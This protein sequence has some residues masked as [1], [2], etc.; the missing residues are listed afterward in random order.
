MARCCKVTKTPD[1]LQAQSV[2]WSVFDSMSYVSSAGSSDQ[3]RSAEPDS[4]RR[5]R[6]HYIPVCYCLTCSSSTYAGRDLLGSGDLYSCSTYSSVGY[7]RGG[8]QTSHVQEVG[9]S[10]VL[11]MSCHMSC[12]GGILLD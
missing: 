4:P 9:G 5:A 10:V 12:R 6:M 11:H 7:G 2:S 3:Y 1:A 8:R